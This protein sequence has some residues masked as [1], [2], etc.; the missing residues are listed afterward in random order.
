MKEIQ[1]VQWQVYCQILHL[2]TI[3]IIH[4]EGRLMR[5]LAAGAAPPCP[6]TH[7]PGRTSLFDQE[8]SVMVTN[9]KI[10]K[11]RETR[12]SSPCRSAHLC[13]LSLG[14]S[15]NALRFAVTSGLPRLSQVY[16][17]INISTDPEGRMNSCVG[18]ALPVADS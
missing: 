18:R 8:C 15:G 17:Y 1:D 12:K 11:I 6:L 5:T 9:V 13:L 4:F 10:S 14:A 3:T 16:S 7:T 2:K